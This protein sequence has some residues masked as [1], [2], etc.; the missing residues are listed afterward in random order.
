V[1]LTVA[2]K[3]KKAG[4]AKASTQVITRVVMEPSEGMA[5]YYVNY[6]EVANTLSDFALI[7]GQIP[8]KL[9][10]MRLKE[11]QASG[12]VTIDAA[13]QLAFPPAMVPGLINALLKQKELFETITGHKIQEPEVPK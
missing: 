12:I 8:P 4:A 2:K 3:T 11:T 7:C 6:V 13:V 10:S 1:G 5:T 9:T